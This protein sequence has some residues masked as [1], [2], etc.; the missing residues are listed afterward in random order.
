MLAGRPAPYQQWRKGAF[1][2]YVRFIIPFSTNFSPARIFQLFKTLFAFQEILSF[3]KIW[4][5]QAI[6]LKLS[7][8]SSSFPSCKYLLKFSSFKNFWYGPLQLLSNSQLQ[9]QLKTVVKIW[10]SSKILVWRTIILPKNT[11]ARER[12]QN[13]GERKNLE[14]KE[15][16]GRKGNFWKNWINVEKLDKCGKIVKI[17]NLDFVSL[18]HPDTC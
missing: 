5:F 17:W 7:Q 3:S 14:K 8:F 16:T 10:K 9:S 4:K 12:N 1:F 6:K 15:K 2:W 18:N 13:Q 11:T